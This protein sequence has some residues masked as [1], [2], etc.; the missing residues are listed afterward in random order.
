MKILGFEIKKISKIKLAPDL[1]YK[2]HKFYIL[3]P[4]A[5]EESPRRFSESRSLYF[6]AKLNTVSIN[7]ENDDLTLFANEIIKAN[8]EDKKARIDQLAWTLLARMQLKGFEKSY[9]ELGMASVL[10]DNEIDPNEITNDIKRELAKDEVIK[11]FFLRAAYRCI[12]PT[13]VFKNDIEMLDYF[14]SQTYQEVSQITQALISDTLN[15]TT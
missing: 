1:I 6:A 8:K 2:G 7:I 13:Q 5:P 15:V 4:N 10:I 11:G 9:L 14:Q 12:N 3:D